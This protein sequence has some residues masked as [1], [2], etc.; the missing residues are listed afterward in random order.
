LTR[1]PFTFDLLVKLLSR[2]VEVI[3]QESRQFGWISGVHF[4]RFSLNTANERISERAEQKGN[5]LSNVVLGR[6]DNQG[7]SR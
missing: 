1:I 2:N 4:N 6:I 7:P 5:D 3:S